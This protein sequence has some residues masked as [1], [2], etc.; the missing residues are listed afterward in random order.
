[1]ATQ[2]GVQLAVSSHLL[3]L[4][5]SRCGYLLLSPYHSVLLPVKPYAE[6]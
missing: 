1:M 2:Y 4:R 5:E 3:S 6:Q